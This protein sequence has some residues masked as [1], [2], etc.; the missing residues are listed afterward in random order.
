[1]HAEANHAQTLHSAPEELTQGRLRRLGEGIGKVVYASEHWVV[2]RERTEIEVL[3]LITLWKILRRIISALPGQWGRRMLERPSK[4]IRLLRLLLQG[5]V[6][7]IPRGIWYTTHIGQLWHSHRE[8]DQRG[9]RLAKEHLAD[10]G[11]VP[12]RIT[13][14]PIRVRVRRWPGWLTVSE[15]IERVESTFD[16]HLKRLASDRQFD[17]VERWLGCLIELRHRGWRHR[18]FS[19][20]AHLKNFGIVR[21]RVVLLD[22]GGLTDSWDEVERRLS[23][24]QTA[25]RPH[26]RLGLSPILGTRP[27]I[28]D[29][30]DRLWQ[31]KV[32]REEVWKA[33]FGTEV[34]A[35]D[36]T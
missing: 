3:A 1:M 26:E 5:V 14:P 19:T 20:D 22:P 10:S 34:G 6:L 36:R 35:D 13:F 25:G 29:R 15:A 2:K 31:E 23:F 27:D 8:K 33:W 11:L 18:L 12:R 32:N 7:V 16:Q 9:E 30:F 28:A 24:E 21:D 4:R 17:E